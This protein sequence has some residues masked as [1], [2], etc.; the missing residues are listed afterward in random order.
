[1][2]EIIITEILVSLGVVSLA[3]YLIFIELRKNQRFQKVNEQEREIIRV[4][5]ELDRTDA[6]ERGL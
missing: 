5:K 2:T 1:M 6:I 4:E 3:S